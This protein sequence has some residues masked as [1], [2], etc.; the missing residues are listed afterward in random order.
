MPS[1][2]LI[3]T[4]ASLMSMASVW[5][6]LRYWRLPAALDHG[7]TFRK[8][9]TVPVLRVG[10]I[11]I[12]LSF[13][14]ATWIAGSTFESLHGVNITLLLALS[15][16]MFVVGFADDL[17]SIPARWRMLA[18]I[19]VAWL[20]H[21]NGFRIDLID[22]PF[23]PR[24]ELDWWSLPVTIVWLVALPNIF[25]LS[26]GMDGLAGGL[27]TVIFV[28][29]G[30]AATLVGNPGGAILAFIM[31][32]AIAG[33]L[34]FNL[35]PAK[36]YL[37]DGGAYLIGFHAALLTIHSSQKGTA[38]TVLA[39]VMVV[40]AYPMADTAVA[41]CRRF[42]YGFP[43]FRSDAEHLHHRMLTLGLPRTWLL[44][45]FYTVFICLAFAALG[46]MFNRG[47]LIP[48]SV[49]ALGLLALA[50]FYCRAFA[51][52]PAKFPSRVR[53]A[54]RARRRVCYAVRLAQ[55]LE[56]EL[57]FNLEAD[58]FWESFRNS[59]HK[60]GLK[61]L[62]A[63]A[64]EACADDSKRFTVDLGAHGHWHL[65]FHED[66]NLSEWNW[67]KIAQCFLPSLSTALK[68]WP[69]ATNIGLIQPAEKKGSNP[70]QT[71]YAPVPQ[72]SESAR[73]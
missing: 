4:L 41:I 18:Q 49:G 13:A 61:P 72:L 33:F 43:I 32:A 16:A 48:V 70:T 66:A 38:A 24:L 9:Q 35:P 37:G 29:I 51:L 64:H 3:C 2:L 42:I 11:A 17:R 21:A 26:D 57:D 46:M 27:G 45:F 50:V 25:N 40:L 7:D 73:R 47:L 67:R 6:M 53:R 59:L 34:V 63:E 14:T 58:L 56:H 62:D 68:R 71:K 12:L 55:M 30:T 10:G 23:A 5:L 44:A 54:L 20:A 22:L 36:I 19:G 52:H 60:S 39:I 69:A 28:V 8:T 15:A 65:S 1:L 31:A